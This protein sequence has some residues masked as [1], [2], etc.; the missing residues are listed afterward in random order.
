M[1]LGV[2]A[3]LTGA[4]DFVLI[5][6]QN[7]SFPWISI[8]SLTM[9]NIMN[10]STHLPRILSVFAVIELECRGLGI[11]VGGSL[12]TGPP[13][14]SVQNTTSFAPSEIQAPRTL[15]DRAF[16]HYII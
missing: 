9:M 3:G 5:S 15:S 12:Q 6:I 10:L 7:R 11:F 8:I 14:N 13:P 16:G 1:E 4:S 2:W